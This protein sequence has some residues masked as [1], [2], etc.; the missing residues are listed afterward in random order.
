MFILFTVISML[1]HAEWEA[2]AHEAHHIMEKEKKKKKKKKKKEN[3]RPMYT[4]S[5]ILFLTIALISLIMNYL[6]YIDLQS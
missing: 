6:G 4:K 5:E 2:N 3:E 1:K